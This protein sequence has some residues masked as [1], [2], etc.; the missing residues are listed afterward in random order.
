MR[1]KV[2]LAIFYSFQTI[3]LVRRTNKQLVN[4]LFWLFAFLFS[5]IQL[6]V[7]T[8]VL[9]PINIIINLEFKPFQATNLPSFIITFIFE[10]K[11]IVKF[12]QKTFKIKKNKN[13]LHSTLEYILK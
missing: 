4:V 7:E 3:S 9:L 2:K 13:V 12:P 10:G 1:K 8:L 5:M 6:K 11:I